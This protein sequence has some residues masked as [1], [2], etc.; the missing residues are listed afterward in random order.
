VWALPRA[1]REGANLAA[2]V[3]VLTTGSSSHAYGRRPIAA[4]RALVRLWCPPERPGSSSRARRRRTVAR[5]CACACA[6]RACPPEQPG[7]GSPARRR[8]T[9]ARRCAC[10]C[11]PRACQPEQ[12]GARSRARRPRPAAA[13]RR[14]TC[15]C[16]R[17]CAPQQPCTYSPARRTRTAA[18]RFACACAYRGCPPP[19][20]CTSQ[21][22]SSHANGRSPLCVRLCVRLCASSLPASAALYPQ[23]GS[24][25]ACGRSPSARRC[26]DG[27]SSPSAQPPARRMGHQ[28]RH[29]SRLRRACSQYSDAPSAC[30][31]P[32]RGHA[33]WLKSAM[34]KDARKL[35][36]EL[37]AGRLA[38][39]ASRALVRASSAGAACVV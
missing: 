19:Q 15:A 2:A 9:A 7:S 11:A 14:C 23:P 22:G 29:R 30:A 32:R 25:H 28:R 34:L 26:L 17:E 38:L 8:R 35:G 5:R 4:V 24:S 21:P 16:A 33:V 6:S 3:P 10:A 1:H 12:P 20:P 27:S 31:H 18:S 36:Q 13:V 37:D 39:A